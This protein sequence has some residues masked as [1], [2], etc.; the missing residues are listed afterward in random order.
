[1]R[2]IRTAEC[3]PDET[4]LTLQDGKYYNKRGDYFPPASDPCSKKCDSKKSCDT[5]G[6]YTVSC[7]P[8]TALQF[9]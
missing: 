3:S 6:P 7:A 5:C 4:V 9:F 8:Q 1:M 2:R